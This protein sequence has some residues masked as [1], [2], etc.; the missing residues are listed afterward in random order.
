VCVNEGVEI[1]DLALW[2]DQKPKKL[3][4]VHKS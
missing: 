3:I 1:Y 4:L 2:I